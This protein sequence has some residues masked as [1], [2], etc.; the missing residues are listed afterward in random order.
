MLALG[1]VLL[2]PFQKTTAEEGIALWCELLGSSVSAAFLQP[3]TSVTDPVAVVSLA[4]PIGPQLLKNFLEQNWVAQ[5]CTAQPF[6]VTLPLLRS[7][8]LL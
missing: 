2:T 1:Q 3:R 4:F 7:A 6:P 5:S 8:Q